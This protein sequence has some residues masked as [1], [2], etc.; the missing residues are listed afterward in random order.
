MDYIK[1]IRKNASGGGEP[2]DKDLYES[3]KKDIY[4][5]YPK[6]SLFRS[7]ALQKEYKSR[8]GEY[9]G[10]KGKGLKNWFREDWVS[11][12]DFLRGDIVKCGD[13]DTQKKFG[14][15]ALC[16]PI[17]I[18]EKLGDDNIKKMIKEKNKLKNKP[19]RSSK[20]LGTDEFNVGK[21][22]SNV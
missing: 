12:N 16:R 18:A 13:S 1:N 19:L 2:K 7:A 14:E 20:V 15:Y 4:K 6:H 22:G 10:D 5:K 17:A 9:V 8:G 11:L 3:V 21:I